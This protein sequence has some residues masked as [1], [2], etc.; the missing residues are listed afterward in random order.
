MMLKTKNQSS[1]FYLEL[2]GF[3]GESRL[4]VPL[5]GVGSSS[6]KASNSDSSRLV[7]RRLRGLLTLGKNI[8]YQQYKERFVQFFSIWPTISGDYNF[9]SGF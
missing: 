7:A 2:R 9:L 4:D 5:S 1:V 8:N 3:L 6:G